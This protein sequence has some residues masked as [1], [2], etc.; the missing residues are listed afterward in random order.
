M[1]TYYIGWDVGAWHTK[2]KDGL[3]ILSGYGKGGNLTTAGN[4]KSTG[5]GKWIV[6]SERNRP[7][8]FVEAIFQECG[9]KGFKLQSGDRVVFG[10]DACFRFPKGIWELCKG[11]DFPDFKL[12]TAIENAYLYRHTEKITKEESIIRKNKR[13]P[14]SAIQNPIGSQS[15]KAQHFL[16]YFGFGRT[17]AIWKNNSNGVDYTAIEV[18]PATCKIDG[19]YYPK[20]VVNQFEKLSEKIN[21]TEDSEDALLCALIAVLFDRNRGILREPSETDDCSEGWIWFP[22]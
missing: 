14:L 16:S 10:I 19:I 11:N 20:S 3:W 2:T 7:D 13:L 5:I 22:K 8:L 18:Y 6:N 1:K 9:I 21:L 17:G 12:T 15:A 4:P